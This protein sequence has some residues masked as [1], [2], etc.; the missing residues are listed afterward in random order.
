MQNDCKSSLG[1]KSLEIVYY[2]L[3]TGK[4]C[5]LPGFILELCSLI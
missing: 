3:L 4:I 1:N 5:K 2:F